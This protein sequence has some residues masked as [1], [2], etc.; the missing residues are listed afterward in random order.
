M[1]GNADLVADLAAARAEIEALR[2][3]LGFYAESSNWR[4]DVR[5][6]GPRVKWVKS[7]AAFDR[8][9]CAKFTLLTLENGRR[10]AA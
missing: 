2:D 1:S 4:R 7:K 6:V 3:A 10:N 9:A 5:N 8:G